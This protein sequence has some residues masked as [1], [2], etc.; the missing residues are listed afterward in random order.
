MI[1]IWF[2]SLD[3]LIVMYLHPLGMDVAGIQEVY[4][5]CVSVCDSEKA[6]KC[7]QPYLA[8]DLFLRRGS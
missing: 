8:Q 5:D 2:I 7:R 3:S 1:Q 6:V 4:E